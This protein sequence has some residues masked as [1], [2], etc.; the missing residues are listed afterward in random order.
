MGIKPRVVG[1]CSPT[2]L[3]PKPM[4]YYFC[5][6]GFCFQTIFC[7]DILSDRPIILVCMCVCVC[8]HAIYWVLNVNVTL[9]I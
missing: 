7:T 8:T 3:H 5:F 6:G 1:N 4:L 2:K 9:A